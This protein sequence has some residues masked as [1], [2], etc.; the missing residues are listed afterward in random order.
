MAP[1]KNFADVL[2][3]KLAADPVL[4]QAV[5][6]AAVNRRI[7]AEIYAARTAAGL[8]QAQ[9]ASLT[10][11]TQSVIARLEDADYE[12][13][14]LTTLK[15]IAR[16]L[17]LQLRVEFIAASPEVAA[18][19]RAARGRRKSHSRAKAGVSSRADS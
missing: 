3:A 18:V 17:G 14:S 12:G 2:R 11:T 8:S 10:G 9:L 13:H 5:E 7:A 6:N 4:A 19:G 1:T 16:A 15:K